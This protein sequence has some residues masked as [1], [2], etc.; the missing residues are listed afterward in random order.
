MSDIIRQ[1]QKKFRRARRGKTKITAGR[2]S[3]KKLITPNKK[4][5]RGPTLWDRLLSAAPRVKAMAMGGVALALA[6]ATIGTTFAIRGCSDQGKAQ[7]AYLAEEESGVR[8][9]LHVEPTPT[10]SP[11]PEPTPT[12]EPILH[13]GVTSERVIPLQERLMELGYMD[14]DTPTDFFG[15][16]TEHG[17]QLFQRQVNFTEAIGLKLDQDGWA[18]EQ[19]LSVLMGSSAPKYCVKEGMEGEDVSQM[20]KQLVDMGYMRKTTGY[21]GDETKAAMKDFQSR[22]GLSA[23][24]L[25]GEKTYEMLYSPKA[26]ESP[27]KAARKKTKA[28]ISKMIEVAKGKLGCRYVL[29]NTGPNSFD[30]SGLVYYCLKQAGSSRRRLTAAGYS[31][32]DEWEKIT[33]INKLKK[34]DLICFYSDNFSKIGHVGIVVSSSMMID[35]SSSNGKVVRRE[36]KTTYWKKHFYCGRRPW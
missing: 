12:P 14:S 25:A 11:T 16:A 18:G 34:G 28:N 24:G 23:D 5:P 3:G 1:M 17:V 35:A 20:Q 9:I 8:S 6:G 7:M 27:N 22:N 21:Y 30:C 2:G 33:D 10:P 19:T 15:P 29:G 32:V 13:R 4:A 36:Y 26:K 31:Q